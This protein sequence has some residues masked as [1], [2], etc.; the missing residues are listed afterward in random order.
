[1]TVPNPYVIVRPGGWGHVS[2][3]PHAH[4]VVRVDEWVRVYH[5]EQER[6]S[7]VIE[8][9]AYDPAHNERNKLNGISDRVTVPPAPEPEHV[10]NPVEVE[11]VGVQW[12]GAK[13]P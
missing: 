2:D 5:R 1:M 4:L 13:V 7:F 10:E 3:N 12:L 11:G 9:P 6:Y 8:H